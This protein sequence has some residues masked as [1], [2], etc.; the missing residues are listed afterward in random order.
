MSLLVNV[1]L[2]WQT[3]LLLFTASSTT[4][5]EKKEE[6]L[7]EPQQRRRVQIYSKFEYEVG[8]AIDMHKNASLV[9]RLP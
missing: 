9:P 1:S 2:S 8:L 5:L 6:P 7:L 3:R 4:P